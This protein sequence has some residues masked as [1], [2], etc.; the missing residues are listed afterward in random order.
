MNASP[1]DLAAPMA[2]LNM[3]KGRKKRPARAYHNMNTLQD[4]S[5]SVIGNTTG[6]YDPNQF[7]QPQGS[8]PY[9]ASMGG[10]MNTYGNQFQNQQFQAG[11]GIPGAPMA[12]MAPM[13]SQAPTGHMASIQTSQ[14]GIHTASVNVT[15]PRDM[16]A[17]QTSEEL[18]LAYSRFKQQ[19][20]FSTP[21][22][23]EKGEPLGYRS[24]Y[25]FQNVSPLMAGTQY[26]AVDQGTATPKFIRSTMYNM[27]ES[28]N[29]RR[30]TKL[31]VAISVRPF[32]PLLASEEPVPVVDMSTLGAFSARDDYD[33]G[34]PRCNR[35]RTFIN[36]SMTFSGANRFICNICQFPNNSVPND[37]SCVID[38]MTGFR[39]DKNQR[40]E[41]H[42]GVYDIIL[43]EYYNVN[44]KQGKLKGFHHV[45]LIDV[46]HQSIKKGLP[47]IIVDALRAAIFELQDEF[48]EQGE[49][50]KVS[51]FK[52]SILL[53][54]KKVHFFNLSSKLESAQFV[55]SPDLEDPFVPFYQGL[56]AD[57]NECA[58]QIEDALNKIED[59]C[60]GDSNQDAESCLSVALRSAMMCLEQVG[61]GKI[62]AVLSS[63]SSW[64]PGGSVITSLRHVGRAPLA[65][66]EKK[67][68]APSNKYYQLLAK[69]MVAQNVALDI[70]AISDTP[71][72]MANIGWLASVTGGQA[73]K[74]VNFLP[75]R[76]SRAFCAKIFNSVHKTV[77]YQGLFKLR[78]STGLQVL[79]YYGFPSESD[80]GIVGYSNP[81]LSD[82]AIPVLTEDQTFTVL[83]EFDGV[84]KTSYDC[85]FQASVLYT[86]AEGVR[87]IRVINLVTSVSER[88]NEVFAFVDQE[89]VAGAILRDTL[90][91][92]GK[93]LI[94]DLRRSVNEKIV[95]V[96]AHYRM[97]SQQNHQVG[98]SNEFLFPESMKHFALFM[99]AIIKTKALRDS[100]S[101]SDDIRLCDL[102]DMMH[103]PLDKLSFHLCPALVELH[104]LMDDDCMVLED[105]ANVDYFIKVPKY[106]PLTETAL[107]KMVYI[108]C[109]GSSVFVNIYPETNIAL[110]QDLFGDF[111]RSYEDIDPLLDCLPELPTL[112]SQQARN[113]VKFFNRNINATGDFD[114]KSIII[115]RNGID[116]GTHAF[117]EC[118]V[119][120]KLPSKTINTSP[121]YVEFIA[122]VHKAISVKLQNDKLTKKDLES[123][124]VP[125]TLAQRFIQL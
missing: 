77:G 66:E 12:P 5:A 6:P 18:T 28:E 41:L 88:L 102:Y 83:L 73:H 15:N 62:T 119:E 118:L 11:P 27:P 91:F 113:I 59:F 107:E 97:M 50:F 31:P 46:S 55:L 98:S 115:V 22:F 111:V 75:V 79:Q 116:L 109:N 10:S 13:T 21:L 81:S 52:Y 100:A 93:Q 30:A 63:L 86:D 58:L 47:T 49:E 38:P 87:K 123:T 74:W 45:F 1:A 101:I 96:F 33:V 9:H 80:S 7:M 36:P 65:E 103:M 121:N 48:N 78:C 92:V 37:Y 89:A 16:A 17:Q 67:A 19:E 25:S 8:D 20:E 94:A 14:N 76:D 108:L 112:I 117:K 57:P 44:G 24:F 29:L 56:F 26:H 69:D 90:S 95:D 110:L 72:D 40:P 68:L 35:C 43:P 32:A 106:M 54:D 114:D 51:K 23:G 4:P 2:N 64:G 61:G 122:S 99:L 85:H 120:D 104:T 3:G 124:H 71:V 39:V 53:F 84:L 60:N 70:F 42:K 34:P 82:P 125:E 105:E